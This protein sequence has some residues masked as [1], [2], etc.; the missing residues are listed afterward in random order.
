MNTIATVVLSVTL[1]D[2]SISSDIWLT[3]TV[4]ETVFTRNWANYGF[5]DAERLCLVLSC[6]V[7][8]CLVLSSLVLARLGLSCLALSCLGLSWLG[9]SCL[10][11]HWKVFALFG[12]LLIRY[13]TPL[14]SLLNTYSSPRFDGNANASNALLSP[15]AQSRRREQLQIGCSQ[16]R[17]IN[18]KEPWYLYSIRHADFEGMMSET[19]N[20]FH[21]QCYVSF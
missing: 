4:A 7:L 19:D 10:R 2:W 11:L 18:V 12:S 3:C 17:S 13:S 5:L 15:E 20:P 14:P 21:F 6:L 9:L 1:R 16:E 8:S